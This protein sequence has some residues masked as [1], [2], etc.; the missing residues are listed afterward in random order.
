M[1]RWFGQVLGQTDP[2]LIQTFDSCMVMIMISIQC[3]RIAWLGTVLPRNRAFSEPRVSGT[4]GCFFVLLIWGTGQDKILHL[5]YLP[6]PGYSMHH[7]LAVNSLAHGRDS[8]SKTVRASYISPLL[9]SRQR[10]LGG[11]M[12][13]ESKYREFAWTS[14]AAHATRPAFSSATHGASLKERNL[15]KTRQGRL[16]KK[17]QKPISQKF[18]I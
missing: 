13:E 5:T 8:P 7:S 11:S 18:G 1:H 2:F 4:L 10:G 15:T 14:F 16:G 3:I 9:M 12:E 6:P 17:T